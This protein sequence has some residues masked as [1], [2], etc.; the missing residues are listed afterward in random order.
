MLPSLYVT[1]LYPSII[2]MTCIL[3]VYTTPIKSTK[4][5]NVLG[6]VFSLVGR[7]DQTCLLNNTIRVVYT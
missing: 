5:H 1:P 4:E 7:R 2:Q 3:L 6:L